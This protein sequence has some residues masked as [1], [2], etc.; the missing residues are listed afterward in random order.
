MLALI[1]FI[2]PAHVD[3]MSSAIMM[4]S[5]VAMAIVTLISFGVVLLP[6]IAGQLLT[7]RSPDR[8][9]KSKLATATWVILGL[10]VLFNCFGWHTLI[11][12]KEPANR[13]PVTDSE[14]Q[15]RVVPHHPAPSKNSLAESPQAR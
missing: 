14:S 2:P 9:S 13:V 5:P 4:H 6:L 7:R 12:K 1:V 10:A 15:P 11:S 3:M 8:W